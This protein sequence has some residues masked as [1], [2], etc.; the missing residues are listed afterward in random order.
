MEETK[1]FC[2]FKRV[3]WEAYKR[4]KANRGAYGVDGQSIEDFERNLKDNLYKIWNRMSSGSYFP[5]PVRRVD[6]PKGDG[7]T[8]PLGIPTVGD[9]VAQMVV[10]MY[11][12]PEVE[13][14][15]HPDSYGYR[16]AKSAI[17]AI[18]TA[19]QRCWEYSW[20]VDLDIKGFFDNIDHDLMMRA[21]RKHTD[22]KWILLYIERWLKASVVLSDGRVE[23]RDKGTP[24]GGVIS[25]LLANIFLH[26]AFD[27]W[28]KGYYPT[29]PFERYADDAIVH[30]KTEAQAEFIKSKIEERLN[31][32]KLE[33]NY[34][35]TNIVYCKDGQ[36]K[37][38][39]PN[40]KFDFLGYTFRP[41]LSMNKWRKT[42]VG[43]NPAISQKALKSIGDT[44]RDWHMQRRS[45][46]SLQDVADSINPIVRGWIN[47]YG[48]YCP[49]EMFPIFKNL[50]NMQV[51]WAR[52]KYK[53]LRGYYKAR[54]WLLRVAKFNRTLFAHWQ[55]YYRMYG[56]ITR[57]V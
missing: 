47:Y 49:S 50:V 5:P 30:C 9:R 18:E 51:R 43:F 37:G 12:E 8:R 10:K 14:E 33:V 23:K 17:D 52:R 3:V 24:Q 1:P 6:I 40:E 54:A 44:I 19:R 7:K 22:K 48:R 29:I 15:F 16:P 21:V 46:L 39:Y 55:W 25:P 11:L 56:G 34:E 42:F 4:V 38:D 35:K 13:T 32:C 27:E 20:V 45:D 28:M 41:R 57:A 26:H 36:R 2:I 31:E 53:K